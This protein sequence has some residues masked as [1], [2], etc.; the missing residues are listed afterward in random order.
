M[1]TRVTVIVTTITKLTKYVICVGIHK[2]CSARVGYY[3]HIIMSQVPH[4]I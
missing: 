1:S 4:V 3:T 2:K